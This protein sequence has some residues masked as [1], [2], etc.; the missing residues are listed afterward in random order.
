MVVVLYKRIDRLF[1]SF[2]TLHIVVH[3]NQFVSIKTSSM[4]GSKKDIR[5]GMSI[6]DS[7]AYKQ[8]ASFKYTKHKLQ[9]DIVHGRFFYSDYILSWGMSIRD[10]ALHSTLT[11]RLANQAI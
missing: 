1:N 5:H 10:C 2:C 11:K 8:F 9:N 7:F 3:N 4:S 6:Q